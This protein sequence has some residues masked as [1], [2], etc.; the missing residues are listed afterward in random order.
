[1]SFYLRNGKARLV[2]SKLSVILRVLK[3]SRACKNL[4]HWGPLLIPFCY[5]L[6]ITTVFCILSQRG[7]G[8]TVFWCLATKVSLKKNSLW[9]EP[10]M[11][12]TLL[13]LLSV[14][15]FQCLRWASPRW[16]GHFVHYKDLIFLP[17][18]EKFHTA[19]FVGLLLAAFSARSSKYPWMNPCFNYTLCLTPNCN[20]TTHRNVPP[21]KHLSGF[22]VQFQNKYN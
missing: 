14:T 4:L 21:E 1:M 15:V 20:L 18:G 11:S 10:G 3:V 5:S 9:D 13:T 22:W 7:R 12:Y 2:K 6:S 8:N 19:A 16:W 17:G